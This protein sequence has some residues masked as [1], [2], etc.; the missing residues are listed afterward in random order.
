MRAPGAVPITGMNGTWAMPRSSRW[1]AEG[2]RASALGCQHIRST[3]APGGIDAR[4]PVRRGEHRAGAHLSR[5]HGPVPAPTTAAA[6]DGQRAARHTGQRG[7]PPE[8][9]RSRAWDGGQ[10]QGATAKRQVATRGLTA[11]Q[12]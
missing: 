8:L 9:V 6:I 10:Q 11:E 12:R 1:K 7:Q 5:Y 3:T 4:P 2:S